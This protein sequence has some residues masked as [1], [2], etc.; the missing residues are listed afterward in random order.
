MIQIGYLEIAFA[1]QKEPD[2]DDGD[3]WQPPR[4]EQEIF[5]GSSFS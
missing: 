4:I 3:D 2:A 1:A 5:V